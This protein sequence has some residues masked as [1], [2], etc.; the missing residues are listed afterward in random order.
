MS[1]RVFAPVLA[2]ALGA[3]ACTR[4]ASAPPGFSIAYGTLAASDGGTTSDGAISD[5]GAIGDGGGSP[6][7]RSVRGT[8]PGSAWAVG[9]H[10]R[11]VALA[12]GKWIAVDSGTTA[13]L[14][15]LS[16]IDIGHAVAAEL[17]GPRVDAWNGHAWGPLGADRAD[18]AAAATWTTGVDD[19]WVVGNGIEHWDGTSW[20][21]QVPSGS[22]FTSISGSFPTDVWAVGPGGVR[23]YD[24]KTWSPVAVPSSVGALTA[25]WVSSLENAWV[26]GAGG[27]VLE[28]AG[29]AFLVL[30]TGPKA[31]LTA[32]TGTSI[33]DVWVGGAD[34]TLSHWDGSAWSEISSPANRP[35]TDL[36]T[37]EGAD[38]VLFVDDTGTVTSYVP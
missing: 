33:T 1:P 3:A 19:V 7:F 21:Q 25:V 18:R 17:G 34:G 16:M 32:V 31:D 36:W 2:C 4:G 8:G 10:G 22:T 15:G 9:E 37:A 23:H 5:G 14:G 20:T 26:V 24:G 29:N 28:S 13:T 35:I 12:G 27:T 38:G 30:P 11:A 6:A